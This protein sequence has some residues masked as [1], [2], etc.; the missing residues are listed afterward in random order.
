MKLVKRI[1]ITALLIAIIGLHFPGQNFAASQ[2]L[3][4]RAE[5]GI[6]EHRPEM[7]APPEID[8]PVEMVSPAQSSGK[9]VAAEKSSNKWLY[10]G[11]ALLVGGGAAIA[12]S[13]KSSSDPDPDP[14]TGDITVS[15]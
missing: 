3:F 2:S 13:G 9:A 14:D 10:L 6:T 8:I 15:W 7:L 4:A 1:I 5:A 12:L 11:G